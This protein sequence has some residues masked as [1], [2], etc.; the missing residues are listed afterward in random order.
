VSRLASIVERKRAEVAAAKE[1]LPVGG[2]E[3]RLAGLAACRPLAATLSDPGGPTCVIG[4]IKRASPSAGVIDDDLDAAALAGSFADHGASAI[5]VLTDTVGF[6]GTLEDLR[7]VRRRVDVPVL[8]KDFIVD[9]YQLVEARLAGADAVLLIAAALPAGELADLHDAARALGL[10][11]LVEAHDEDEVELALGI[12]GCR[13]IGLNSRD[14][15][16]FEVDLA[17]VERLSP[18]VGPGVA[19]VAE[20]GIHTAADVARLRRV[21]IANFLVGEALVRAPDPGA[22]LGEFLGVR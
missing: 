3:S 8:R 10:E 6:G 20:S 7:A 5:S 9:P 16:T 15:A 11:A 13:L 4:E 1:E 14:L 12:G 17:T 19:V 22:L 2:I 18:L 21:G